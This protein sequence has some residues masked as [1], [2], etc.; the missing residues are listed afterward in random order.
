MML[1]ADSLE[2]VLIAV[3]VSAVALASLAVSCNYRMILLQKQQER[4]NGDID[5]AAASHS[6]PCY[7]V[8]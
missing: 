7:I 1:A 3:V 6:P 2:S 8:A 5:T 4:H